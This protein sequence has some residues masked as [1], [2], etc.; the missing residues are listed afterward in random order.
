MVIY[1]KVPIIVKKWLS[2]Y[3]KPSVQTKILQKE[4]AQEVYILRL[5]EGKLNTQMLILME[6]VKNGRL[7][8]QTL[9]FGETL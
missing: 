2:R 4:F 8:Y 9:F 6:F 3:F 7:L 5:G 1:T